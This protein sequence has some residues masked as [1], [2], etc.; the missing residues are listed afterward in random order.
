MSS[1]LIVVMPFGALDAP[2][3]GAGTIQAEFRAR[4]IACDV[5]YLNLA[6]ARGIGIEAYTDIG[7]TAGEGFLGEWL[8]ARALFSDRELDSERYINEV[9]L[10]GGRLPPTVVQRALSLRDQVPGFL[11]HCLRTIPWERYAMVGFTS[12]FEQNLASLALAKRVKARYPT[13]AIAMGGANCFGPMGEQLHRSF[14]FLDYVFTGEADLAFADLVECLDGGG[15]PGDEIKGYVRREGGVSVSSG[16]AACLKDLDRLPF[17]DYD[18]FFI[19]YAQHGLP[20]TMLCYVLM[21]TS[22]GCWWGAKN[23][24]RFCGINVNEIPFR[25]KSPRRAIDEMQHL[26]TRYRTAQLMTV[27]NI[28]DLQ[29]F[30]TL[31][32]ELRRRQSGLHLFYESKANLRKAQV[33]ELSEAGI[34]GIQPGIE[35]FGRNTLK[36]MHKGVTPLQNAALLKWCREFG[37]SPSWNLLF[38][39]P[40]ETLDDYEANIDFARALMHCEPP[41]GFGE[42][43]LERFSPLLEQAKQFGLR[44]IRPARPY[45]HIYPFPDDV[46]NEIAF[47]FE[48]DFDGKAQMQHWRQPLEAELTRWKAVAGRG[49]LRVVQAGADWIRVQDTRPARVCPEYLLRGPDKELVELCDRPRSFSEIVKLIAK[50]TTDRENLGE[51]RLRDLLRRMVRPPADAAIAGRIPFGNPPASP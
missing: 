23:Q 32:P 31:I 30:K 15:A 13:I 17:P 14:E 35:S 1:V 11:D 7:L 6:F 26:A 49:E 20:R 18:D 16:A 44:G 51:E 46:L 50:R 21:E 29:F 43:R 2:Q 48:F 28:L 12:M 19:Q 33:Q 42:V 47:Y 41:M 8:F 22:R 5:A 24:C 34:N 40:G 45:R 27:D 3:V 39:F 4:G 10:G 36:L 9:L 38:G 25:A 37:V